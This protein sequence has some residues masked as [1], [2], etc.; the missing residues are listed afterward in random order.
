MAGDCQV[1]V[2]FSGSIHP[3]CV[4]TFVRRSSIAMLPLLSTAAGRQR[5]RLHQ[6]SPLRIRFCSV[7]FFSRFRCCSFCF[8]T[9]TLSLSLLSSLLFPS[10]LFGQRLD[11]LIS[12]IQTLSAPCGVV[13]GHSSIRILQ[14]SECAC[15][16]LLSLISNSSNFLLGDSLPLDSCSLKRQRR[17]WRG[18][19]S[20]V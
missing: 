13:L 12:S 16:L 1:T 18:V 19:H 6:Q 4:A 5:R 11:H 2:I 3:L 20:N 8:K 14:R 9:A 17:D 7:G 10:Y 15:A